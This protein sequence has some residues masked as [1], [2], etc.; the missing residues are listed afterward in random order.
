MEANIKSIHTF[1]LLRGARAVLGM[2]LMIPSIQS[3]ADQPGRAAGTAIQTGSADIMTSAPETAAAKPIDWRKRIMAQAMKSAG[4]GTWVSPAVKPPFPFDELI[5]DWNVRLPRDEGFRLYLQTGFATGDESPWLYAGHWGVVKPMAGKRDNPKFDCGEVDQDHLKLTAAAL[6]CRFKVVSE[7]D[8]PLTTLPSIGLIATITTPTAAHRG[9][10]VPRSSAPRAP[11]SETTTILDIPLRAQEDTNGYHLK[12]RCQSAALA[13]AMEYFG[14]SVPLEHIICYTTDPEY[15]SFGIWPR[16][17]NTAVEH[18]FRAYLDRF[19]DWDSVRATVAQNKVILCSITMPEKD[20]YIA[21]PYKR[22]DGHIVAL[23]G[24]TPDGRVVVTDSA[25]VKDGRGRLLQWLIPDFEKI[26]MR[27]KGGV[28]MVICPPP[29]AKMRLVDNL[30]PFP[31]PI[32]AQTTETLE[33]TAGDDKT[34]APK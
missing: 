15:R 20:S 29:G 18:G 24:V 2:F 17:I 34:T 9:G 19:R 28:G 33:T 1:R 10:K 3:L 27:N 4:A 16:T 22:M 31:R 25:L 23:N 7:G 30:P 32:R 8:K 6:T 26:W 21:P 5:Y 13:S 14:K 11:P 12:D